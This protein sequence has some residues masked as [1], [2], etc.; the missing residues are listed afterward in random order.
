MI[1]TIRFLRLHDMQHI[2]FQKRLFLT[3]IGVSGLIL[4][5][6]ALF[7][8]RYVSRQLINDELNSLTILN[9]SFVRQTDAV[10]TGLD[11]TSA[12]INYSTL[13]QSR[14]DSE[15][16]LDLSEVNLPWL[17]ELF[18]TINGTDLKCDQ[19]NIYDLNGRVAHVGMVT[20]TGS[21]DISSLGWFNEVQEL[22][23]LK[24]I[25][26]PYCTALYS[27]TTRISEWYISLYRT[28]TNQYNRR[29]GAVETV[30]RCKNIFKSII[31]YQKKNRSSDAAGVYVFD[32]SGKL[33]YPYENA[34]SYPDA[35]SYYE[36]YLAL[37]SP[38]EGVSSII[39]GD[40][41][42][43]QHFSYCFSDYTGWLYVSSQPD[44]VI[45]KPV[46]RLIALILGVLFLLLLLAALLSYRFSLQLVK[47]ISHLKHIIQRM[48]IDNLGDERTEGYNTMYVELDELYLAFQN[49]SD[50]LKTSMDDLIES[51]QQEFRATNLALQSQANPHFY[52][53]TLSSIIVL[54]ENGQNAEVITLCRSLTRI[55]RYITDSSNASVTI[56]EEIEN[57]RQYLY[58]MKVRYQSSLNYEIVIDEALGSIMIPKLII[59]PLVENAIKYGTNCTPPWTIRVEGHMY[60][61]HWQIDVI[62]SGNGFAPDVLQNIR[63]SIAEAGRSSGVPSLHINGLG[64]M[65]VY[66]R[67]KFYEKEAMIFSIDN[68]SDGHGICS[69]GSG[70]IPEDPEI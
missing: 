40:P 15:H 37:G 19:I 27:R 1:K 67:W 39:S 66:L 20:S 44:P 36:K 3:F 24:K 38:S 25:S 57:V 13:M 56:R 31:S 49:M 14:L 32:D 28:Y 35:S 59:Q 18:V 53:N 61:D 51:R 21:V 2:K 52:Y 17:A 22:G 26:S 68:T 58:C 6:F 48:G 41:G 8:Y 4:I 47:P 10:I 55:M 50:T 42:V 34:D 62:D 16:N 7:F 60:T 64:I 12:N 30:K 33:I 63:N 23:G 29:V 46:N 54:A 70:N 43:T 65:N 69:I 11:N 5:I 9:E 45:L